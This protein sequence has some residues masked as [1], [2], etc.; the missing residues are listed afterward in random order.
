MVSEAQ[1]SMRRG[2]GS[3]LGIFWFIRGRLLVDTTPLSEAELY[4]DFLELTLEVM[5]PFG[6]NGSK[7]ARYPKKWNTRNN[8]AGV[9]CLIRRRSSSPF[10]R[11][12]AF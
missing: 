3:F 2:K 4:G 9:S 8:R 11:T 5:L 10:S 6:I 7:T 12:R 1:S